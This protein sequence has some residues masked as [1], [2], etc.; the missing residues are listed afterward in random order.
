MLELDG[1][2]NP[3]KRDISIILPTSS[4]TLINDNLYALEVALE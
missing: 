4:I 1:W 2:G 3:V